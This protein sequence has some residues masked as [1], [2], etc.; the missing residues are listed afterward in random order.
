MPL[1]EA[2]S[3]CLVVGKGSRSLAE[4]GAVPRR[5]LWLVLLLGSTNFCIVR[6]SLFSQSLSLSLPCLGLGTVTFES[7]ESRSW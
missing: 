7:E 5:N 4:E 3:A 1:D 6:T 2:H